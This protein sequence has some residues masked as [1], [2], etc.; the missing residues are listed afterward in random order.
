MTLRIVQATDEQGGLRSLGVRQADAARQWQ[1][2]ESSTAAHSALK[3]K[4]DPDL[5]DQHFAAESAAIVRALKEIPLWIALS[6]GADAILKFWQDME[7]DDWSQALALKLQIAQRTRD[8]TWPLR[9][10]GE[11]VAEM[12]RFKRTG[13]TVG[14]ILA[15]RGK[16]TLREAMG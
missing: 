13:G 6:E 16:R 9:R 5:I 12:K 15:K 11:I 2:R 3:A 8:A 4:V 10:A 1:M 7:E 14:R